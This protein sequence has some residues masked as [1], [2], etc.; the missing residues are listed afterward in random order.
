[1]LLGHLISHLKRKKKPGICEIPNIKNMSQ[2]AKI[3]KEK[4]DK[5]NSNTQ[6][7]GRKQKP[8]QLF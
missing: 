1:M 2:H 4:T 3:L 5:F 7:P 6:G 8:Y